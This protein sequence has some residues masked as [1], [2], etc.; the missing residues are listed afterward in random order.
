MICEGFKVSTD[1]SGAK[2]GRRPIDDA[3][4]SDPP[5]PILS[6]PEHPAQPAP[7]VACINKDPHS[8]V[9]VF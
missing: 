2:R 4:S 1:A 3:L 6:R 5:I 7:H 8:L 9:S